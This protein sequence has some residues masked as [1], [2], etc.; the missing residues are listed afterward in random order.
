MRSESAG[1]APVA[2]FPGRL[3][4]GPALWLQDLLFWSSAGRSWPDRWRLL[5][6]WLSARVLAKPGPPR[7]VDTRFAPGRPIY[8][9][10]ATPDVR[11]LRSIF[12]HGVYN[13]PIPIADDVSTVIDLGAYTGIST[14]YFALRY[15]SSRILALEPDPQNFACLLR[16]LAAAPAHERVTAVHACVA[17]YNGAAGFGQP[18]RS[19][20][21]AI[22]PDGPVEVPTVVMADLL[23]RYDL[24]R[25]DILKMD[26]EGAE[27]LVFGSAADWLHRVG[28]I[29]MELHSDAMSFA[30]LRRIL[31]RSGRRIF[32]RS[33]LP[34]PHWVE[35]GASPPASF[36]TTR[37]GL[38]IV[39]PPIDEA[40]RLAADAGPASVGA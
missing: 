24:T 5:Y 13:L 16:N 30:D 12:G 38:D 10:S 33:V 7:P 23:D 11:V 20:S 9:R 28:W 19:W 3:P 22:S 32:R 40:D 8:L 39:I 14:L 2:R 36:G 18:A 4:A 15:R 29:L 6:D 37:R 25:V 26:I 35:L 17:D 31:D 1:R 34:A 27:K 21:H